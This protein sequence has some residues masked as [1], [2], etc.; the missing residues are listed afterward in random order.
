MLTLL[1]IVLLVWIWWCVPY[2]VDHLPRWTAW[3]MIWGGVLLTVVWMWC[4]FGM[5]LSRMS[6]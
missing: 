5:I 2:A 4:M 3:A 1:S 6:R